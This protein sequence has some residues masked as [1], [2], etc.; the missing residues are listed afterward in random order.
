MPKSKSK[1]KATIVAERRL[2][3]MQHAA[4]AAGN[5]WDGSGGRRLTPPRNTAT[6]EQRAKEAGFARIADAYE[7]ERTELE[8]LTGRAT[9]R[10][11]QGAMDTG[12]LMRIMSDPSRTVRRGMWHPDDEERILEGLEAGLRPVWRDDG[13]ISFLATG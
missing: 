10:L 4:N 11:A 2:R 13:S 1:R 9:G 7:A 3:T 8:V 5:A 6:A 12:Q